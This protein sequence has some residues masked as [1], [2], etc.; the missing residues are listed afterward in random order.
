[1]KRY[2]ILLFL[3]LGLFG[4]FERVYAQKSLTKT[5]VDARTK[6]PVD[7]VFIQSDDAKLKQLSS[8]E[9]KFLLLSDTKAK[10]FSFYKMGYT[11]QRVQ[12]ISLQAADTVFLVEKAYELE[13][14]VVKNTL[15]DTVVKDKRYYVDDYLVLANGDFL[16]ITS[17]INVRGCEVRYFDSKTGLKTIK[18]IKEERNGKFVTDCFK[19]IHLLTDQ[20]SRQ[21]FF[22]S[23]SSFEFLPKYRRATFDSTLAPC[24]LKVDSQVIV[25]YVLPPLKIEMTKFNDTE[26]SSPFLIYY[27][28]AKRKTQFFY[29]VQYNEHMQE[30]IDHELSDWGHITGSNAYRIENN[31]LLFFRKIAGPLYAP[32][33]LKNDTVV[34]FNFQENV[35]VFLDKSGKQLNQVALDQKEFSTLHDFEILYDEGPQ[36]FYMQM[37]ES[38]RLYIKP[39][40]IYTGKAGRKIK[41]EK[42]FATNIQIVNRHLYYLA[43]ERDWDDTR[44]LYEQR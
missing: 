16:L 24:V 38:D 30:M 41:L 29:A 27:K 2:N 12:T 35:I 15:L 23:D 11:L 5:V 40:N 32:L 42:P 17:K 36:M 1:M 18:K 6:M 39:L 9:G 14:V 3:F 19:N 25:R 10:W 28:M 13:E 7:Y 44:Y 4:F 34:V 21:I 31:I 43:K 8:K 20:F 26:M 33:F 22:D 37:K